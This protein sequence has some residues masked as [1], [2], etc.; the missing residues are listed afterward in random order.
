MLAKNISAAPHLSIGGGSDAALIRLVEYY[1]EIGVTKTLCLRGDQPSGNA[2]KPAYA[3]DLIERLQQR[4]PKQFE[5]AV[6]AYPEVQLDASSAT[7][8]LAH[9]VANVYADASS[10]ISLC[11]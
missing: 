9:C 3:K 7:D 1:Q 11:F 4:F 10:A 5:L 8:D 2:S 6:A